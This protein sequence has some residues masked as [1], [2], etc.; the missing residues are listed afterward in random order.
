MSTEQ[1]KRVQNYFFFSYKSELICLFIYKLANLNAI[2]FFETSAKTG[3]NISNMFY[4]LAKDIVD[5]NDSDK[6]NYLFQRASI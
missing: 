1:G 3:E 5:K 4:Q 2:K 6:V